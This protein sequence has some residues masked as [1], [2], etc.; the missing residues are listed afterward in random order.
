MKITRKQL[1][2]LIKEA[3]REQDTLKVGDLVRSIDF[4]GD[5]YGGEFKEVVGDEIGTVVEIDDSYE[6][7]PIQ[8]LVHW[9]TGEPTM[10]DADSFQLVEGLSA[11][12]TKRQLRRL[13]RESLLC[14]ADTD[15]YEGDHDPIRIEIPAL[16]KIATEENFDG[17]KIWFSDFEASKIADT[18]EDGEPDIERFDY[19]EARY[20]DA[21]SKWDKMSGLL[22]DFDES[23]IDELVKNI[24]GGIKNAEN[25]GYDY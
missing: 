4:E 1:R 7:G 3:W 13:I 5:G 11:N 9:P 12:I 6:D 18:L 8:Y 14:E 17:K 19:D 15:V 10:D 22:S 25:A 16:E 2:R 20:N 23:N 24:R 21:K